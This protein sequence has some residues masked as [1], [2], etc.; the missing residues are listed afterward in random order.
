MTRVTF[1]VSAS[2]FIANMC[3]KQNAIDFGSQYL[4]QVKT[5]FHVDDYLGGADSPQE[6][7]K[8]Q[9]E[10]HTL[11]KKGGFLLCKWSSSDPSVLEC[12]PVDLSIDKGRERDW[13]RITC[14]H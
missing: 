5:S 9:G 4:K 12:I 2:S 3:V 7:V 8:L 6:T 10:M 1:G 13:Q 11:F 14:A